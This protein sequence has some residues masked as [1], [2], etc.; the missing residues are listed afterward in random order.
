MA[1][2]I[3]DIVTAMQ[4]LG[5]QAAY[6]ALYE[7]VA[8][9]RGLPLPKTWRAIV[10]NQVESYS[11]D[12]ENYRDSREDLFYSVGGLGSGAWALR[13][14]AG[15]PT[16]NSI[17]R[18]DS[19][20][21]SREPRPG[22]EGAVKRVAL[23]RYERDPKLRQRCLDYFGYDCAV[24]GLNFETAYGEIGRGYIHVHHLVPLA[25][26]AGPRLVDPVRDLRPVC[27]N[28]HAMLHRRN[29]PIPVEELRAQLRS[30]AS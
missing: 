29:P 6:A 18:A 13:K 14:R 24:C 20:S 25:L 26:K 5:G 16:K 23:D 27:P 17:T 15:Y 3:D 10:R 1:R 9:V 22:Y 12:S 30:S 19:A 7:E 2:W 8:R 4:N 21:A 11:S 28:C